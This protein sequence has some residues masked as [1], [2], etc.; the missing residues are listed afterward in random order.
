VDIGGLEWNQG[1]WEEGL[2]HFLSAFRVAERLKAPY[3]AD[4]TAKAVWTR[5]SELGPQ[6]EPARF[7]RLL[8]QAKPLLS[9]AKSQELGRGPVVHFA[10]ELFLTLD[11][12]PFLDVLPVLA[13]GLSENLSNL[14]RPLWLAAEIRTSRKPQEL[15]EESEEMRR[16]VQEVLGQLDTTG[17]KTT[18]LK[19]I[20]RKIR[21]KA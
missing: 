4:W 2:S 11:P 17:R 5:L 14:L 10:L 7:H 13:E 8:R 9:D 20:S 3:N 15:P 12:K 18:L 19:S 1:K 16:A 21:K 6:A